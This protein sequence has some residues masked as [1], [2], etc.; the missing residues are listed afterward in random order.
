MKILFA[1]IMGVA[2]FTLFTSCQST[3]SQANNL[4]NKAARND[5]MQTIANDSV[6]SNE[7]IQAMMNNKNG[8][9]M[10]QHQ[11]MMMMD[12][13]GSMMNMLKAN[14]AMM[15]GMFSSMMETAKGD[16][17]MMRGMVKMMQANSQMMQMMQNQPG[18]SMMNGMQ[19]THS[20]K[21]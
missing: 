1:M 9:I 5:I 7:M 8:L 6:M 15:Q 13:N 2:L 14:P 11:Q 17:S 21:H 16:S 10:M 18:N 20:M 19:A 3:S 4:S 12:N